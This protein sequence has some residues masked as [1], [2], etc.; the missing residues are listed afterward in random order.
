MIQFFLSQKFF[1]NTLFDYLVS[2]LIFILSL[3]GIRIFQNVFLKRLMIWTK[4]RNIIIGNFIVSSIE[5]SI[6]PLLYFCAF[7]FGLTYLKLN[8]S[9]I[10]T[11]TVTLIIIITFFTVQFASVFVNSLLRHYWLRTERKEE[12][13]P[14]ISIHVMTT[15]INIII[16]GVGA[17]L[18]LDNLGFQISA[19]ITGLGISSIAIAFAAQAVLSDF[20]SYFVIHLDRPFE[21]GDFI[22]VDNKTGIIESIGLKTTR[23]LSLSGEQIIFPNS[24]LT[25]SRIHNYK[26]MEKRRVLFTIT[27]L[28]QIP[29]QKLKEI[30]AII[31]AII[32]DIPDTLFDRAHLQSYEDSH[33]VFEITYYVIGPDYHKYMDT[34]QEINFR[35]YEDFEARGITLSRLSF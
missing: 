7:Y 35:I 23:V 5:K 18:L 9:V 1:G 31:K 24:N 34:Q 14:G 17:A 13:A 3:I 22:T 30:P 2:A 29:L 21:V 20:F 26:K 16:W 10:K 25:N 11:A 4:N 6:I 28:H 15:I 12:I 19:V 8:L 33:P 27:V 32:K